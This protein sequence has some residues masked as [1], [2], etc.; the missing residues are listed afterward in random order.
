MNP[1]AFVSVSI[2][3]A[4]ATITMGRP[5]VNALDA[6]FTAALSSALE[7]IDARE[8]VRVVVMQ[9]SQPVFCAGADLSTLSAFMAGADPGASL[10]R[11]ATMVQALI[12]RL[13]RMRAATVCA[14]TGAAMGGGMEL[15]L[16]ADFRIACARAK[17]G[18]PEVA[19][20]LIPAA[21]GTQ[22]VVRLA[23]IA[24][25]RRMILRGSVLG[26][27][28]ALAAGLI[29]ECWTP[30]EFNTR[31]NDFVARLARQPGA[32]LRSAKQCLGMAQADNSSGMDAE[33]RQIGQLIAQAET[34]ERIQAFLGRTSAPA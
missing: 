14:I 30:E 31:S 23:G 20:G 19:L 7:D 22:R 3:G 2:E 28:D 13:E 26:A 33:I 18:L 4:V 24:V 34:R 29:D 12:A 32:A 25:A 10:K 6:A 8:E 16:G 5:S 1:S 27:A 17:F 21:G 15:A 9:S 11:Y